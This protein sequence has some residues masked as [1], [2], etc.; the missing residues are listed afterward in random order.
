MQTGWVNRTWLKGSDDNLYAASTAPGDLLYTGLYRGFETDASRWG[1]AAK[2]SFYNPIIAP[3]RRLENGYTVGRDGGRL[4]V[5]TAAA[6][7]QGDI[8]TS[9][10]Q[11][12]RQVRARESGLDGYRQAQTAAARRAELIVGNLRPVYDK[13]TRDLRYSPDAVVERVVIGDGTA[14]DSG[15]GLEAAW[16]DSLALGGLK[17]YASGGIAVREAVGVAP[18]GE[19]GLHATQVDV[20]ADLTARGGSIALG[21]MVNRQ[22]GANGGWVEAPI[23]SAPPQAYEARTLIGE[24]VTLDARGMWTNLWQDKTSAGAMPY[25]DGGQ[26]LLASSG[27]VLLEAGSLVDVSSGAALK[28][29]GRTLSGGRGGSVSLHANAYTA[30]VRR[31][32]SWCWR[33]RSADT[34][35]REGGV[36]RCGPERRS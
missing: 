8:E 5:A 3:L 36:C 25:V 20:L 33:A 17:V 6:T 16:L 9:T 7:L 31:R 35:S 1:D 34:A 21:N 28:A 30:S 23:A 22:T 29:D 19:I 12:D 11:G 14:P 15:I 32:G 26:I 27:D 4:V 13:E 10:Y 24:G 18:G 2:E